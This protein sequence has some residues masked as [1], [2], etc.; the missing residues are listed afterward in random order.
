MDI[1]K[2]MKTMAA[3]FARDESGSQVVEYGLIIA[4]VSIGLA[5]ALSKIAGSDPFDALKTKITN[6]LAGSCT[7]ATSP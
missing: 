4:L 3:D 7:S 2:R 1:I 6:C 5:V